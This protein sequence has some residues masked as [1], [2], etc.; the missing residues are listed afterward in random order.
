MRGSRVEGITVKDGRGLRVQG[1]KGYALR[2]FTTG[3]KLGSPHPL[4]SGKLDPDGYIV[5]LCDC[6]LSRLGPNLYS[7]DPSGPKHGMAWPE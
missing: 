6:S 7:R 1:S 5:E 3:A 4:F 2:D